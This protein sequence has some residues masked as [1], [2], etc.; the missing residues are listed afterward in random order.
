[1][2]TVA[3]RL[4]GEDLG[5]GAAELPVMTLADD[6]ANWAADCD[7]SPGPRDAIKQLALYGT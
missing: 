6:P 4:E 1:M 7:T 2:G 5:M 3:G